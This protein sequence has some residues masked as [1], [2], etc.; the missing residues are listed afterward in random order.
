MA[1]INVEYYEDLEKLAVKNKRSYSAE[2]SIAVEFH[3]AQW[4]LELKSGKKLPKSRR[5]GA[6]GKGDV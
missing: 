2:N 4:K 3:I 6:K 5:L 1:R